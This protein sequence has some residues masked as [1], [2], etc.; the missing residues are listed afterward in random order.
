MENNTPAA[1]PAAKPAAAK[2][3]KPKAEPVYTIERLAE[4]HRAFGVSR[5]IAECALKLSGKESFTKDE[6]QKIID[7]FKTRR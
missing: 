7:D 5:A 3:A 2:P 4:G 1:A 6:A